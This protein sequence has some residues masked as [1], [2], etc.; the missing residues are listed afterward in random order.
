MKNFH[1][2]SNAHLDP[3]WLWEWEEGAA[4]AISTFRV[5]ADLCEEFDGFIFNEGAR[6]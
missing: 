3:V 5:A 2:L 4:E 6:N 1:L